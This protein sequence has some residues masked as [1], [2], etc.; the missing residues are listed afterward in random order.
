MNQQLGGPVRGNLQ[1]NTTVTREK[2][3]LNWNRG[4]RGKESF[5]TLS[6][7]C[8]YIKWKPKFE[9]KLE[10]QKSD[11]IVVYPT[12]DPTV[13]PCLF[14]KILYKDQKIYLWTDLLRIFN[15]LHGR[16]CR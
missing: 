3:Y 12:Y 14:D 8:N 5:D 9:A 6:N 11:Y 13:I 2:R 10:H 7:D 1:R 15:N 4:R 16:I